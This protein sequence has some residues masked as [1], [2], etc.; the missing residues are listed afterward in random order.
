M[1]KKE[2]TLSHLAKRFFSKIPKK[3]KKDLYFIT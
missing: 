1:E 2:K 3:L